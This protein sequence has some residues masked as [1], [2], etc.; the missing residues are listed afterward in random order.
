M[1]NIVIGSM[2][3]VLLLVMLML[4]YSMFGR[5]ARITELENSMNLAMEETIRLLQEETKFRPRTNDELI[6]AFYEAF[7]PQVNAKG[8][9]IIH[10]LDVDVQ[11]GLLQV[12]V[13]EQY[14]HL[15]GN[16]GEVSVQKL[17]LLEQYMTRERGR[18]AYG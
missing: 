8:N 9:L 13:V 15:N 10:V 18:Y 12:E 5:G 2:L 1:K 6:A 16:V 17:I 14:R 11:K 3:T 4:W 7:L